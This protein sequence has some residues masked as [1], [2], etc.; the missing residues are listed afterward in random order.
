MSG[1]LSNLTSY[2]MIGKQPTKN[3]AISLGVFIPGIAVA[4]FAPSS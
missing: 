2:I 3:S 4:G 1:T